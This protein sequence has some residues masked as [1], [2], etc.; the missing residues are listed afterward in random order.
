MTGQKPKVL[1]LSTGNATHS[2]IAEGFLRKLTGDRFDQTL[3]G[4]EFQIGKAEWNFAEVRMGESMITDLV[5]FVDDAPKQLGVVGERGEQG[6]GLAVAA[7]RRPGEQ[8]PL[9]FVEA[10]GR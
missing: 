4:V 1:F 9:S 2:L 3:S 10:S 8:R 6:D 5:S 7:N